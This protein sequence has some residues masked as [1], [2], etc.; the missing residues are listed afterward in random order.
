MSED[1]QEETQEETKKGSRPRIGRRDFL[2]G[3]IL[4]IESHAL[5]ADRCALRELGFHVG[6]N[7]ERTIADRVRCC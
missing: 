7:D 5:D 6:A 4:G 1:I 2:A 3:F